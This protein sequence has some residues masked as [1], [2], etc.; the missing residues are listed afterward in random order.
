MKQEYI[1]LIGGI[2]IF[3]VLFTVI[4]FVAQG[5]FGSIGSDDDT[6]ETTGDNEYKKSFTYKFESELKA[7]AA[8]LDPTTVTKTFELELNLATS[9]DFYADLK[10]GYEIYKFTCESLQFEY[11]AKHSTVWPFYLGGAY[12]YYEI[13]I[14][15]QTVAGDL[16]NPVPETGDKYIKK[17]KDIAL[18]VNN[19]KTTVKVI[20]RTKK[21]GCA[22]ADTNI[23]NI[24]IKGYA[25]FRKAES[26]SGSWFNQLNDYEKFQKFRASFI[27]VWL[28]DYLIILQAVSGTLGVI[29]YIYL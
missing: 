10:N 24:V 26:T 9:A 8:L 6:G 11:K 4:G 29:V 22:E 27:P 17:T 2:V 7:H 23:K 14:N 28:N 21:D 12:H 19:Y 13:S 15:E 3:L 1:Q 18:V 20:I 16:N 5:G 25:F